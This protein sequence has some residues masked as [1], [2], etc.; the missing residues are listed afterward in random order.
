M[1]FLARLFPPALLL[2]AMVA[3]LPAAAQGPTTVFIVRHAEKA[4]AP[5]ADP[6]LTPAGEA[7]ARALA[8]LLTHAGIGAVISTPYARTRGT[9]A[10][11]A[12][13]RGLTV[14]TVPVAGGV[15]AHAAAVAEAV[16]RHAGKAVLVVG[17]SNTVPAI[18]AALGAPRL[19]DLC[20]GDYDQLFIVELLPPGEPR[21]VRA[22][23]GE[24]S[25]R[26]GC[27]PMESR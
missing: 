7:R 3:V 12:A 2:A 11:L 23:F 6:P 10:P 27:T 20:D 26:S 9:A 19:P 5:A 16:R 1:R 8:E 21:F 13:A 24:P 15:P 22:R 17:H 14:E 25:P 4:D 18:A